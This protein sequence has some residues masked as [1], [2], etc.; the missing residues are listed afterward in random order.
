MHG[1]DQHENS[2]TAASA[3]ELEAWS[4]QSN[5][6]ELQS[7]PWHNLLELDISSNELESLKDLEKLPKLR[8]LKASHNFLTVSFLGH[9]QL[10]LR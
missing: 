1:N 6:L 3:L 5:S 2:K 8:R 10:I 7:C 9:N 4:R